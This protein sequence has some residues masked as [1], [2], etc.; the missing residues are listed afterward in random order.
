M[1]VGGGGGE[2]HRERETD[3]ERE[4]KRLTQVPPEVHCSQ[5]NVGAVSMAIFE[6][7]YGSDYGILQFQYSAVKAKQRERY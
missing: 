7:L 1:V 5:V 2:R 3:R 4:R 6:V